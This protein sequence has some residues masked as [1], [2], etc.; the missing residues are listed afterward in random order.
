MKWIVAEHKFPVHVI[1]SRK[2]LSEE[3]FLAGWLILLPRDILFKRIVNF[4]ELLTRKNHQD[5]MELLICKF[6]AKIT[7][8]METRSLQ[9][10]NRMKPLS[11]EI[12]TFPWYWNIE[13]LWASWVGVFIS[14]AGQL[15]RD[16]EAPCHI[17]IFG[18]GFTFRRNAADVIFM[19]HV[20][21]M[22][23]FRGKRP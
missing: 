2:K 3:W 9:F 17:K 16:N 12:N 7:T 14:I 4:T 1:R 13:K 8:K 19:L 6:S 18:W 5:E 21:T 22:I 10:V 11:Q 23:P 15:K 20:K